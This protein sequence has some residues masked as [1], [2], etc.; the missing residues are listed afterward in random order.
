MEKSFFFLE[1]CAKNIQQFDEHLLNSCEPDAVVR[2]NELLVLLHVILSPDIRVYSRDHKRQLPGTEPTL[3]TPRG[4]AWLAGHCCI[5]QHE[6]SSLTI[7]QSRRNRR[8]LN[9]RQLV[10]VCIEM[11]SSR[12]SAREAPSFS[13]FEVYTI[14]TYVIF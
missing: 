12:S 11:K 14:I 5:A 9:F 7:C 4:A 8:N 2:S 10:L 13:V 3:D 6:I 1:I